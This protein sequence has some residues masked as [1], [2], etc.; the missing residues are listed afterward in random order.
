MC[1]G[2]REFGFRMRVLA[3]SDGEVF[4]GFGFGCTVVENHL[5]INAARKLRIEEIP[6]IPCD[7]WPA[8]VKAFRLMVNRSV[9]CASWRNDEEL[10]A[11][12]LRELSEDDFGLSLTVIPAKSMHGWL[13]RKPTRKR[14]PPRPLPENPVSWGK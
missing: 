5:R 1:S 2:I 12:K 9:N 11:L 13:I 8:Q 14:M 4:G 6:V 3:R 7:E 10:L